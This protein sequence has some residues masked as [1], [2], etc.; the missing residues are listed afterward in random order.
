MKS[1][2]EAEALICSAVRAETVLSA[3]INRKLGDEKPIISD[4]LFLGDKLKIFLTL[5]CVPC[6]FHEAVYK[7]YRSP[8]KLIIHYISDILHFP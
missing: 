5:F 8:M 6:Q 1:I 7:M 4:K 3:L 2:D